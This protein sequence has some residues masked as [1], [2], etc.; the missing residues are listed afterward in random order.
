MYLEYVKWSLCFF[1]LN[2][3]MNLTI[4]SFKAKTMPQKMGKWHSCCVYVGCQIFSLFCEGLTGK[5]LMF[6]YS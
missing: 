2:S 1:L 4:L 6:V 5:G 3:V